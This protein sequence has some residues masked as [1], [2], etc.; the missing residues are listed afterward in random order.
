MSMQ[1][2]TTKLG[3]FRNVQFGNDNAI[4]NLGGNKTSLVHNNEVSSNFLGKL[5]RSKATKAQNNAARTELLRTLGQSFG[6]SGMTTSGGMTTFSADFIKKLED[7]IGRDVLKTGDFKIMP[8]G[9]VASGN[10]LTQRRI[11]AI[12][13][14]AIQASP[15]TY[16]YA[17]YKMKL[18]YVN[19]RLATMPKGKVDD[20][21]KRFQLVE[22]MMNFAKDEVPLLIDDNPE[23]E[24]SDGKKGMPFALRKLEN[25]VHRKKELISLSMVNEY[26]SEMI[27]MP[28]HLAENIINGMAYGARLKDVE[29]PKT[30]IPAYFERVMTSYA[31]TAIDLFIECEKLGKL[32]EFFTAITS[33]A[34]CTEAKTAALIDF[35]LTALPMD[36]DG[37]V[38]T[39]NNDQPLHE[40]IGREMMA[41]IEKD[42]NLSDSDDFKDF[43]AQIKKNLVGTVRPITE[44]YQTP[45]GIKFRPV[46]DGKG[47]PVVRAI[48]AEDI[49][50]L[51][52]ACIDVSN[53]L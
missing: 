10:P 19:S 33:F 12:V 20:V 46:L 5:F 6:L 8:D 35:R 40:C 7:I 38:A 4:A 50:R 22:K 24:L 34:I 26:V 32:D 45:H 48:T 23:Y 28:F 15:G 36:S 41:M 16:N 17:D 47:N 21:I 30:Q 18:D 29:D 51:G 44:P 42:Q 31:T 13:N 3:M 11:N 14:K 9:T 52:Q 2:D 25:G 39:H 37:P 53:G 49:D 1:I 43:A 27:G